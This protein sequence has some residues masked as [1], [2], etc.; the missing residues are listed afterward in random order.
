MAGQELAVVEAMKMQ[1]VI[2]APSAGVVVEIYT[3]PGMTLD[4]GQAILLVR[5]TEGAE[6]EQIELVEARPKS[7]APR[8]KSPEDRLAITLDQARPDAV[9]KLRHEAN[10][11]PGKTLPISV[12]R[13]AFSNMANWSMPPS[14]ARSIKTA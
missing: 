9:A 7:C 3:E 8:P 13:V 14:A 4:A 5:P 11:P 1:H 6:T 12:I 2:K 10:A